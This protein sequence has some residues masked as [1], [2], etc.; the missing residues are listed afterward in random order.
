LRN[1]LRF[2]LR[3][4]VGRKQQPLTD[5]ERDMVA[6]ALRYVKSAAAPKKQPATKQS[7]ETQNRNRARI[8]H[9]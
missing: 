6:A 4:K 1:D 3:F 8:C 9:T 7:D 2:A 5:T